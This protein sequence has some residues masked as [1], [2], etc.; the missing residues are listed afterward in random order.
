MYIYTQHAHTDIEKGTRKP[1][2][3]RKGFRIE[4]LVNIDLSNHIKKSHRINGSA[5][6]AGSH[7]IHNYI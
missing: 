4:Y 5:N 6:H 3:R 7:K 2:L 1:F